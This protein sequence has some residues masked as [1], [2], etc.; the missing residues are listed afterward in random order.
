MALL[1]YRAQIT[2]KSSA[3][4]SSTREEKTFLK[5]PC[6][7]RTSSSP[8]SHSSRGCNN[9]MSKL[10]CRRSGVSGQLLLTCH[11][12]TLVHSCLTQ[13]SLP[14][15]VGE[16]HVTY[17]FAPPFFWPNPL[18]EFGVPLQSVL[19]QAFRAPLCSTLPPTCW[20]SVCGCVFFAPP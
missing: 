12:R 3:Q 6:S 15:F 13:K 4:K 5:C 9:V 10:L 2:L 19:F 16:K 20:R 18:E 11:A 1:R 7:S 8:S 17:E 14:K